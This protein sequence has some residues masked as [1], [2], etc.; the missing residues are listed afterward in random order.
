MQ[1]KSSWG[2]VVLFLYLVAGMVTGWSALAIAQGDY[3][4]I[5]GIIADEQGAPLP[6]VTITLTNQ[7]SGVSRTVV[8]EGDGRY[9]VPAIQPGKYTLKAELAGFTAQELHDIEIT[10]G[11]GLK[12]DFGLKVQSLQETVTVLG[13]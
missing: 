8:S 6:G 13:E 1:C 5:E 4:T 11:L 3:G 12:H 7:A 2:R 10:I 9:R